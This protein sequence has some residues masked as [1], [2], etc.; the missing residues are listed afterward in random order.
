MRNVVLALA[1]ACCLAPSAA[2][3][4]GLTLT[5]V[6]LPSGEP[7]G[8]SL[9]YSPADVP[10][11]ARRKSDARYAAWY[12]EVKSFVD[13]QLAG[14]AAEAAALG[15]DT[16]SKVAKGAALLHQLGDTPPASF[17]HYRDAA[18]RAGEAI[19]SRSAGNPL[20]PPS[21]AIDPLQDSPRL[22]SLA[23]AYD[24]LRGTGLAPADDASLRATLGQWAD[25]LQ[26]DLELTGAFG[27]PGHRD[28]WGVK[29]GAA[30]VTC[31]LTLS[32]D[33]RAAGWLDFGL[34]LLGESL[35][36]VASRAGWWREGAHYL[37]YALADL[38]T[39][40]VEVKRRAGADWP[41]DL[42]VL[43][44]AALDTRLPDGTFAPFEEGVPA[45]FPFDIAAGLWPARAANY[46]WAWDNSTHDRGNFDNQALGAATRFLLA[47]DAAAVPPPPPFTRFRSGDAHWHSLR[48]SWAA[49]ALQLSL[50]AACDYSDSTLVESRHNT[51][52]PLDVVLAGAGQNLLA[53]SSGGPEVTSSA[54]RAYYL[55]ASSKNVPLVGG[56]APFVTDASQVA[57]D[58]MLDSH[59]DG[60]RQNRL[61][62]AV[63]T[64]VTAYPGA[65]V[66]RLAAMVGDA[67]AL[68]ADEVAAASPVDFALPLHGRGARTTSG[69]TARWDLAGAS[70]DVAATSTQPL[71][72][73]TTS[74]FTATSWGHEES[75]AGV[76][77]R[78]SAAG[79][80]V[81]TLLAPRLSAKT[82]MTV[83][84]ASTATAA[85]LT[86]DAGDVH[87]AVVFGAGGTATTAAGLTTDATFAL[88]RRTGAFITGYA[89]LGGTTLSADGALLVSTS[90]PAT[91]AVTL[92]VDGLVA[93]LS[94]AAAI[95]LAKLP[96]LPGGA[97]AYVDGAAVG[98]AT[99][100]QT[101]TTLTVASGAAESTLRVEPNHPPSLDAV[102]D[103]TVAEGTPLAFTLRASDPDGT[104]LAYAMRATPPLPANASL[105]AATGAFAWTPGFDV[106]TRAA[107]ATFAVTFSASDGAAT[108]TR[109]ATLTVTDVP[110][111][112]VFAALPS[113]T[114]RLGATLARTVSA[115]SPDGAALTYAA[116]PPATIDAATGALTWTPAPGTA[117]GPTT[118]SVTAS[119][120]LLSTTVSLQVTVAPPNR[121]PVIASVGGEAPAPG[122]AFETGAGQKLFL[123]VVISDPDGDA[124]TCAASGP[125][126]LT[127]EAAHARLV[128]QAPAA[129]GGDATLTCTD[130]LG[131]ASSATFALRIAA[132]A[133]PASVPGAGCGC[134]GSG[135]AGVDALV[136]ALALLA[137][138]RRVRADRLGS[139]TG[140]VYTVTCTA[141]DASGNQT[142]KSA[143]ITVPHDQRA[144]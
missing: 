2:R 10:A 91:A 140:R 138:R 132:P 53:T 41:A 25:A 107:P 9:L 72:L 109:T 49:D 100:T 128:W 134:R 98:P 62:D 50:V 142:V 35:A 139:G 84:S 71:T 112:P 143:T 135:G 70:L 45:V 6:A 7:A 113:A 31:A 65:R 58:L 116:A 22:Q 136:F 74:G 129:P 5:P 87:D 96:P 119:D 15:D 40:A 63:R 97:A 4:D 110:R 33:S 92:G 76:E 105:D 24:S 32:G 46:Q 12:G 37:D 54:N 14:L 103:A 122:L 29:A 120:G 43:A 111:A 17:A 141:T 118:L 99:F 61:L 36:R 18:V 104:P 23:E 3:A 60:A 19:G 117:L 115:T 20:F 44:E 144:H 69:T 82:A 125:P 77:L 67:Y 48:S 83:T 80:R 47:G 59:D 102:A 88:V 106:A 8:P 124:F 126:T 95:T 26:N 56:A 38:L 39:T 81:L 55:L 51:Q 121:A 93:E 57:D 127:Y 131:A 94:G 73:A 34:T 78:V 133:A 68:L 66:S 28:N 42:A 21:D 114:V 108:A 101:A 130:S 11:L 16:L 75:V 86:L 89:M 79:A 123:S 30:L 85:A 27:V 64:T 13:G 1:C 52:N 137:R 90:A